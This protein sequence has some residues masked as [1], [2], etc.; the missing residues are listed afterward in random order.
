M[1]SGFWLDVI[2][3]C[4]QGVIKRILSRILGSKCRQ[5]SVKLSQ[6]GKQLLNAKLITYQKFIPS[7][8]GRKLEGGIDG[9]LKWK[10]VQYK[11]L[12]PYVGFV[13]FKDKSLVF[14]TFMQIFCTMQLQ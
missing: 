8:F 10:A 14:Q 7:D 11:L 4:Y 12:T 2:H 9:I 13:L 3:L 5:N 1:V 6:N